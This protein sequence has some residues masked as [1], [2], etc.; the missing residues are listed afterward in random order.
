MTLNAVLKT[1][2]RAILLAP[3]LALP[4]QAQDPDLPSLPDIES[5][6]RPADDL[7]FKFCVDPRDPAWELDLAVGKA[8]AAA[9]LLEADPVILQDSNESGDIS[10]AYRYLL[11]SCRAYFGFKLIP[12]GYADWAI[13]SRPYYA[14]RYVFA[15]LP[16]GPERLADLAAGEAVATRVGTSADIRFM[17]YNNGLATG[18]RWR[19][20]PYSTD[21]AALNAVVSG[22]ATAAL[23]W[24]PSLAAFEARETSA[25]QIMDPMPITLPEMPVAA[26]LLSRDGYLRHAMDQAIDT[27]NADGSLAQILAQHASYALV[28]D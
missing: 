26:L 3:F 25:F 24:Q 5:F 17:Q 9:L 22:T 11:G 6:G 19:R 4:L 27:L 12:S 23:I 15:T 8:I 20:F 14:A 10:A 13:L 21:D 28:A 18:Q 1:L 7:T 16:Q 2:M